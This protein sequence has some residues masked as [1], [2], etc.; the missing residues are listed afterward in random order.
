MKSI[1]LSIMV[2]AGLTLF[3][4]KKDDDDK[5]PETSNQVEPQTQLY[6]QDVQAGNYG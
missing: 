2:C 6:T 4:C 3:S 5:N 1:Q